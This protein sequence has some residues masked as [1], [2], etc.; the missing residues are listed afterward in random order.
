MEDEALGP[1]ALLEDANSRMTKSVEVLKRELN[2]VRTGRATPTLVEHLLVDYY[3]VPT[4]LNQLATI[5]TPEAQLILVQPWDR[6]A[7]DGIERSLLKSSL[8]LNP[9]NDGNL[10][11]IPIPHLSQERRK[12]LVRSLGKEVEEGKVAVRNI[13]RD[14]QER[15]RALERNKSISQ[16]ENQRAQGQLQKITDAHIAQIDQSWEV[17]VEEMM[18]V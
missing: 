9:S 7:I 2:A 13:R 10:I 16:D 1:D 6:Q 3:G 18:Q 11:R 14:A 15:L 8:G 12:E 17:K 5:S 4:A